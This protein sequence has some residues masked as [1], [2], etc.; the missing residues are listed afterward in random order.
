M[1]VSP[2]PVL[3]PL[4]SLGPRLL[5]CPDQERSHGLLE[6]S[7]SRSD[8]YISGAKQK[9]MTPSKRLCR[10]PRESVVMVNENQ[11]TVVKHSGDL[12]GCISL[13]G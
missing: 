10:R 13:E 11:H 6:N 2:V 5:D 9:L 3:A 4:G 7:P 1:E 8:M 12:L